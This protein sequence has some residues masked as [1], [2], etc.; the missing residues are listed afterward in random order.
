[1]KIHETINESYQ[2]IGGTAT[3]AFPQICERIRVGTYC[4]LKVDGDGAV[5]WLKTR[6]L[7]E[8]LAQGLANKHIK[9]GGTKRMSYFDWLESATLTRERA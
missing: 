2:L 8:K 3:V 5:F 9:L 1:M 7:L 4:L 6:L